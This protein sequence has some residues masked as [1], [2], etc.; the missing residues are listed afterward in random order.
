MKRLHLFVWSL[1]SLFLLAGCNTED[2]VLEIFL[3][4]T[5]KLTYISTENNLHIPFD[6]WGDGNLGEH[7]AETLE[8]EVFLLTFEGS[9]LNT[10]VGGTFNATA[11]TATINGQW[12]ADGSSKDMTTSNVK[13]SYAESNPLAIAF[14]RGLQNAFR[15]DGDSKNLYI[16]YEDNDNSIKRLNL[17]AQ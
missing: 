4:K 14:V 6:F 9:E 16:Y 15:Y 8:G 10:T 17:E 12:N 13:V 11:I 7:Y 3:G 1:L 2:D 5:W